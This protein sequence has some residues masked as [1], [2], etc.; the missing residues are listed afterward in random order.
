MD[1]LSRKMCNTYF[2]NSILSNWP[3]PDSYNYTLTYFKPSLVS[4]SPSSASHSQSIASPN[5]SVAS[6]SFSIA[7]PNFN[8]ASPNFSI[9]SLSFSLASLSFSIASL[10]FSLASPNFRLFLSTVSKNFTPNALILSNE[11]RFLLSVN[12]ILLNDFLFRKC[13][14]KACLVS[15]L[16]PKYEELILQ[17]ATRNP[18]PVTLNQQSL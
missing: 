18:N 14:D 13:R 3:K 6:L 7:S 11:S 1:S 8:V 17:P 9:A 10:S 4:Q 15:T 5:F 16:I 2:T 12:K